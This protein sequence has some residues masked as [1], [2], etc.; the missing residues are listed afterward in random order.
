MVW[1]TF[2]ADFS[3]THLV[4]QLGSQLNDKIF[5]KLCQSIFLLQELGYAMHRFICFRHQ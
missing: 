5:L 3:Q 4:T 2:W 1:A